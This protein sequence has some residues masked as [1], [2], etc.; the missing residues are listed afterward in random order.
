MTSLQ[1]Q[2]IALGGV[3]QAAHLVHKLAHTGQIPDAA[4]AGM[5]NTILVPN[6]PNVL[7]VY[8]G[9]DYALL[10]GYR[11]LLAALTRDTHSLPRESLRYAMTLIGLERQ[12]DSNKDMI[13]LTHQHMGRIEEQLE[14]HQL[15]I[16]S[17]AVIHSFAT[18]YQETISTLTPRIQVHGEM[19]FLQHE[20]TAAK[21]R[22]LLFSG[23]R[24]AHLWR[25][26]GGR[27]WHLLFK[28][29]AMIDALQHR[30]KH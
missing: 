26:T 3:F 10:D 5:L 11:T 15:E 25:H 27:R 21:I 1:E 4:L 17:S 13:A 20:A 8:G 24:S 19:R 7:E 28:R 12:F 2:L 6:K 29:R 14:R 30:L 18:L 22:A 23:I 9:D 16:T